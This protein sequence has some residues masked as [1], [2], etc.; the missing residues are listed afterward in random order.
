MFLEGLMPL[1]SAHPRLKLF[2]AGGADFEDP[3]EEAS[4]TA[5][6]AQVP[7][8]VTVTGAMVDSREFLDAMDVLV[9][10]SLWEEPF[11][12]VAVEG[13]ARSLPVVATRSGGLQEI[14]EHGVTGFIVD[15]DARALREAVEPLLTDP[16]LRARMGEAGRDRVERMFHPQTQMGRIIEEVMSREP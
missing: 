8:H 14:V 5:L 2:V 9:V 11:G 6:A 1:L 12:L 13:M 7:E 10:P 4:V 15:K 16:V 3:A